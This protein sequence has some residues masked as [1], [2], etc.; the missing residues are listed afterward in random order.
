MRNQ[1]QEL[2]CLNAGKQAT[3]YTLTFNHLTYYVE[4]GGHVVNIT[5]EEI[6]TNTELT[7][8]IDDDCITSPSRIESLD[9]FKQFVSI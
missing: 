6:K 4:D 2:A 9:E 3:V 8:I 5:S 1:Y 7:D